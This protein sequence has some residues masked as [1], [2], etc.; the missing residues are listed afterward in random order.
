MANQ[1]ETHSEY[2]FLKVSTDDELIYEALEGGHLMDFLELIRDHPEVVKPVVRVIL[3]TEYDSANKSGAQMFIEEYGVQIEK[4]TGA[5]GANA[6][7]FR[8][9]GVTRTDV[10]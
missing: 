2:K 9:C 10:L 1:P 7:S 6:S 3:H 4:G 5:L 8:A